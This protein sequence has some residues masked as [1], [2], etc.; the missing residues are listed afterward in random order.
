MAII[1]AGNLRYF[2][3]ESFPERE[4]LQG[5][6][7]RHGGVSP[8]PWVSLNTATTVGDSRENIIENRQRIFSAVNRP[9]TSIFDVWQIHSSHVICSD[10]PRALDLPHQKADAIITDR[11]EITLFMRFADCVPIFL[12][13]PI[14]KVTAIVHA[15]WKGTVENIVSKSIAAMQAR[16]HSQSVDILAGIGPSI[17]P[18]H[19]EIRADVV[20]LVE[21]TFGQDATELLSF[22][23]GRTYFDLWKANAFNLRHSGVKEIEYAGI[24]TA[25]QTENWYSHRAEKGKTGR[26]GAILALKNQVG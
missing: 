8:A 9:V 14:R 21:G 5:I 12:Y 18:D 22:S 11:P 13:D 20:R 26:F 3:F 25:C 17:G 6:F 1:E 7:M 24:C 15:G 16:Y 10:Q 2:T 4:V 23:E 19:Y